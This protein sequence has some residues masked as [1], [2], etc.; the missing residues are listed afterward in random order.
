[1][2]EHR[3]NWRLYLPASHARKRGAGP[4]RAKSRTGVG[5]GRR[6]EVGNG[7]CRQPPRLSPFPS[8]PPPPPPR[9]SS[10]SFPCCSPRRATFSQPESLHNRPVTGPTERDLSARRPRPD[11]ERTHEPP[12]TSLPPPPVE[13]PP[14]WRP[15]RLRQT[16]LL[17]S[18]SRARYVH[19]CSPGYA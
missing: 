15:S 13:T 6:G 18:Q 2:Q 14:R 1:M 8:P 7:R 19:E 16:G 17:L 5:L 11:P 10:R 12:L 3:Q 9:G 4:R